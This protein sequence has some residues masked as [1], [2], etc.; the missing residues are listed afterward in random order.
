[1]V[2]LVVASRFLVDGVSSSSSLLCQEKTTVKLL[3]R[4]ANIVIYI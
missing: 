2:V 1:M 3:S 4:I